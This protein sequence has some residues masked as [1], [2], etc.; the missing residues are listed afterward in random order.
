MIGIEMRSYAL[1]GGKK[2]EMIEYATFV[3]RERFSV[4][5]RVTVR[6]RFRV[7]FRVRVVPLTTAWITTAARASEIG[8]SMP[9]TSYLSATCI[10][11]SLKAKGKGY[12][13]GYR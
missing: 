10:V 12:R 6:V 5:V 3:L 4:R 11:S 2:V 9:A 7:M 1:D 13:E 8:I